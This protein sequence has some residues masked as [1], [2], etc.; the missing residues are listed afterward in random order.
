MGPKRRS[1]GQPASLGERLNRWSENQ[2]PELSA[3][4]KD[5]FE[6]SRDSYKFDFAAPGTQKRRQQNLEEFTAYIV[7]MAK[8][9][10]QEI[11]DEKLWGSD[12][13]EA[14]LRAYIRMCAKEIAPRSYKSASIKFSTLIQRRQ[15]MIFW[16]NKKCADDVSR[17]DLWNASQEALHHAYRAENMAMVTEEKIY[18][19][20]LDMINLLEHDQYTS[21]NAENAQQQHIAWLLAYVCG[22]RPGT[23]GA[24][25]FYG[26]QCLTWGDVHVKRVGPN[27]FSAKVLFKYL[28]GYRNENLK[29]LRFTCAGPRFAEDVAYSLGHRL[30]ALALR[31]GLLQ[32]YNTVEELCNDDK[33]NIT[34]KP[35]A[36]DLPIVFASSPKGLELQKRPAA[37][38]AISNYMQRA[39]LSFG[40][41]AGITLYAWRRSAGT[42]FKDA[43]NADAAR[44]L[45]GHEMQSRTFETSYDQASVAVDVTSIAM[46]RDRAT[47]E[48][49][50]DSVCINR[51]E[52]A[53]RNKDVWIKRYI[54]DDE[55]YQQASKDEQRASLAAAG[56]PD[57]ETLQETANT[58]ARN[59]HN[60]RRSLRIQGAL[61]FQKVELDTVAK[62]LTFEE[63]ERRTRDAKEPGRLQKLLTEVA[64]EARANAAIRGEALRTA[65]A[66]ARKENS[67]TD[68]EVLQDDYEVSDLADIRAN[69][70]AAAEGELLDEEDASSI[71]VPGFQSRPAEDSEE[72]APDHEVVAISA[73]GKALLDLMCNQED[74]FTGTMTCRLCEADE[75]VPELESM[76]DDDD[77]DDGAG[78][79]GDVGDGD[80][81]GADANE[82]QAA[83]GASTATT[84]KSKG[85]GKGKAKAEEPK[86]AKKVSPANYKGKLWKAGKLKQHLG[87]EFH[88]PRNK[89]LRMYRDSNTKCPF[90][91]S[92]E[93]VGTGSALLKHAHEKVTQSD[94]HLLGAARAGLFSR[95]FD[96]KL[97][98]TSAVK[99]T[100]K[101]DT[102]DIGYVAPVDPESVPDSDLIHPRNLTATGDLEV[103]ETSKD[104]SKAILR[105]PTNDKLTHTALW[106][107]HEEG[108]HGAVADILQQQRAFIAGAA[109][110]ALRQHNVMPDETGGTSGKAYVSKSRLRTIA[111]L[112][113]RLEDLNFQ[114]ADSIDDAVNAADDAVDD[115][116]E[117]GGAEVG[118]E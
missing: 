78:G 59:L 102:G 9:A 69:A 96:P 19:T 42:N 36:R 62:N 108:I 84:A 45:L 110:A 57:N 52:R 18:L 7:G 29:P 24:A 2:D 20:K 116:N 17:K 71:E 3:A 86:K 89:F 58:A 4:A 106:K 82:S 95:E 12:V 15:S 72:K 35:E 1:I 73:A 112:R 68:A 41:P 65:A 54:Q 114:W 56:S 61:A 79:D 76:D 103:T 87:Q 22:V 10:G 11:S 53:T 55:A 25:K 50:I 38:N 63:I 16:I 101:K 67:N 117:T 48:E 26:N 31:R 28:K 64:D 107:Q 104:K 81:D 30:L 75:T 92:C 66:A 39:C 94:E 40:L 32:D 80:G 47:V 46:G 74:L 98:R 14:N 5:A 33:V 21:Y 118:A 13:V 85:K 83:T 109:D 113:Q 70:R 77:D 99:T 49:L 90:E 44:G 37:S 91:E 115:E 100:K 60:I 111:V 8:M 34:F 27:N 23:I 105:L 51:I 88:T 6:K 43:I 93:Y 97:E